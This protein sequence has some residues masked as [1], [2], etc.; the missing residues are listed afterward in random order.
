MLQPNA[1][2][3]EVVGEAMSKVVG[4]HPLLDASVLGEPF[5]E[6]T[7]VNRPQWFTEVVL[8]YATKYGGIA[9]Q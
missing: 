7:Q 5:K 9:A 4:I 6:V 3:Q 1:L 8:R 2:V